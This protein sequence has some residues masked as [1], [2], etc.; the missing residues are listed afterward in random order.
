VILLYEKVGYGV[1]H[2]VASEQ[3]LQ[4]CIQ[5][6]AVPLGKMKYPSAGEEQ[7]TLV[8]AAGL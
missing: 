1:P 7:T 2:V 5:G 4:Y 8:G 3:I 6:D